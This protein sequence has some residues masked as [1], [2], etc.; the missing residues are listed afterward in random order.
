MK[1]LK[2]RGLVGSIVGMV[3]SLLCI[4]L[5][6][7]PMLVEVAAAPATSDNVLYNVFQSMFLISEVSQT[8]GTQGALYVASS[9]VMIVFFILMVAMFVLSLLT[10]IGAT[11]PEKKQ[12]VSNKLN[13]ALP[14]RI[15]SLIL[16]IIGTVATILLI[17]YF[18]NNHLPSTTFGYGT[19]IPAALSLLTIGAGFTIPSVKEITLFIKKL[20]RTSVSN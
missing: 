8:L 9:V 12:N 2:I 3:V 19:I 7:L 17:F 16:A 11:L 15:I 4:G 10:L 20:Q 5:L 1:E 13:M 14:M 18:E 6:F